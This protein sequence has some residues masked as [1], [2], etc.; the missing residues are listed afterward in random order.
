MSVPRREGDKRRKAA[1]RSEGYFKRLMEETPGGR[2]TSADMA[3]IANTA[4]KHAGK[5]KGK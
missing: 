3:H 1:D 2:V 4:N 5:I